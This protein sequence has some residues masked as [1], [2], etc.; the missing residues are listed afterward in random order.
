ME[1][2]H[3]VQAGAFEV[4]E[5][6]VAVVVVFRIWGQESI[7]PTSDAPVGYANREAF[8]SPAVRS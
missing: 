3:V 6:A 4:G 8:K 5:T 1:A 2:A 7:A